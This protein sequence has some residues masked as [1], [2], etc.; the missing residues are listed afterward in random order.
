MT[1]STLLV[2]RLTE[3][4]ANAFER[5]ELPS[6]L[7]ESVIVTFPKPHRDPRQMSSYR[8]STL[9]F[10]DCKLLGKILADRYAQILR[11]L[12]HPDQCG[13][14]PGRNTSQNMRHLF[15]IQDQVGDAYPNTAC[16]I[17]DLEKAFD[18]LTWPYLF[19]VLH[20]AG[21]GPTL[22]AYTQLLYTK[23][24]SRIQIGRYILAPFK[25]E[26]GTR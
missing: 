9:L 16:L 22:L 8:P 26:R 13:F 20:R 2:P 6:S 25:V 4:Y 21:I 12:V 17:L 1:F 24:T 15:H 5:R 23:L 10:T 11:P 19:A 7:H 18:T 14:V 3:M